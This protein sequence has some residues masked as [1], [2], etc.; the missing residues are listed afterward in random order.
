MGLV[1]IRP[2][3]PDDA[4]AMANLA[5]QLGYASNPEQILW[6]L[7]DLSQP[8]HRVFVA[9]ADGTVVGF[10]HVEVKLTLLTDDVAEI[11]S[12]VV[13][14]SWREEG[15][16]RELVN[17]AEAWVRRRG[18][19]SVQVRSNVQRYGA[20]AFYNRLGYR[21]SKTSLVF[22]KSLACTTRG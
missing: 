9:V 4:I 16:G 7:A 10:V 8:H 6:R 5:T 14:Q 17:T 13:D 12:L 3:T 1:T 2:A 18:C 22:T 20:H 15:V 19:S 21:Q 11:G